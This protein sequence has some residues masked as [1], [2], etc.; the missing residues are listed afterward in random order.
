MPPVSDSEASFPYVKVGAL[1]PTAGNSWERS[2]PLGFRLKL[3]IG[4]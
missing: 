3:D 1:S 4:N 2:R